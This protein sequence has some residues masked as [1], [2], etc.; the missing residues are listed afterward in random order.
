MRARRYDLLAGFAPFEKARL[1]NTRPAWGALL[2]GALVVAILFFSPLWL[3][4]FSGYLEEEAEE[5]IFP[6][7]FYLLSAEEQDMY[8]EMYSSDQQMAIDFVGARLAED[9]DIEEPNLPAIDPSPGDVQ[10]LLSGDF[11]LITPIRLATGTA[12]IYRLSDGR[13]VLRLENLD[14][15]NG[16]ELHVLLSA[17]PNPTTQ[18]A[19]DQVANLQIDLGPLKGNIGNQNYLIEDP[20]FNADNFETVFSYASLRQPPTSP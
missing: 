10:L 16:P 13:R 15:T 2:A 8:N 9:V 20:A 3:K 7:A 17:Y 5:A 18:A 12:S 14:A 6:D 19:L 11:T 1:M 4:E